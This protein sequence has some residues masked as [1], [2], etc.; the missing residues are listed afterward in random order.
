MF[1]QSSK[2]ATF[3]I[4]HTSGSLVKQ[5]AFSRGCKVWIWIIWIIWLICITFWGHKSRVWD[6]CVFFYLLSL[7]SSSPFALCHLSS[8]TSHCLSM[9]RRSS[10]LIPGLS[11]RSSENV[12]KS[13]TCGSRD[14]F[15]RFAFCKN[16]CW[17]RSV[18]YT[19]TAAK[20]LKKLIK[21]DL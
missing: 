11:I 19:I 15:S 4:F 6:P 1:K 8:S 21:L 7:R 16:K 9:W 2:K 13:D 10:V 5:K 20:W 18:C 17:S 3:T 14:S 12:K